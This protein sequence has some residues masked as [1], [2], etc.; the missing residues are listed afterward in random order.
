MMCGSLS[1]I[2]SLSGRIDLA[3]ITIILGMCLIFRWIYCSYSKK[4]S[5]IGKQL[6]SL[7]DIITFGLA[8]GILMMVVIIVLTF[9]SQIDISL[10][11]M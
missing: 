7:A 1:I 8:P 6:D 4:S 9:Q 5:S 10:S 3:I 11:Q 2:F